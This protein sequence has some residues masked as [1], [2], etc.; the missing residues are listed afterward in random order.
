MIFFQLITSAHMDKLCIIQAKR[1]KPGHGGSELEGTSGLENSG[2][3]K[4]T[5]RSALKA[6]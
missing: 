1:Q 4:V 5:L 2:Q 3:Q 6:C